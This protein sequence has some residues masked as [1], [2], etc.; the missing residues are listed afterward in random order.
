MANRRTKKQYADAFSNPRLP[1]SHSAGEPHTAKLIL[2]PNG[3]PGAVWIE[4]IDGQRQFSVEASDGPAGLS[5][6]IYTLNGATPRVYHDGR[7][8]EICSY[9]PDEHSQAYARWYAHEETEA[10]VQ[11]LGDSYRRRATPNHNAEGM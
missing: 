9:K 4:S 8:L 5:I 3:R 7:Y 11:L 1:F 2:F 6:R 10:D